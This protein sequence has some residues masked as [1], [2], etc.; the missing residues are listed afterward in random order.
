MQT[1][2]KRGIQS[3]LVTGGLLMLGT[4]IASAQENVSPDAP[5]PPMDAQVQ[6]PIEVDQNNL[7][8]PVG[9]HDLPEIKRDVDTGGVRAL[10]PAN[11]LV[12]S[13]EGGADAVDTTS[14][15]TRGNVV[16]G[17]VVAPVQV[18]GN[19]IAAG[20]PADATSAC[21]QSA[22]SSG[23]IRTDGST[24]PFAG[25]V[26]AAH[27]TNPVAVSGNAV[28]VGSNA[29]SRSTTKQDA[30]AGGDI[31]TSG[32]DSSLSGNITTAQES[33]PAQVTNNAVAAGGMATSTST[34][35]STATS[36]GAL[37]TNGDR[38]TGTGNV[39]GAPV[40]SLVTVNGNGVTA[41]GNA[42]TQAAN[43]STATAGDQKVARNGALR[44][45]DTSG[46]NGTLAGN[47]TEPQL[48]GPVS[49]DDNVAAGVGNADATSTT[50]NQARAGGVTD[51][52]GN[53]STVSGNLGD[54]PVSLPVS[55]GGNALS[56]VGNTS[57]NRA[58]GTTSSA[59][60]ETLTN[61]DRSVLSGNA[62]DAP[63]AAAIDL[64]G[65]G[66][67]AGGIAHAVCA[68]DVES[69]AGGHT[70]TGGNDSTLSG[71]VGE[72]P[73]GVPLE[74]FGN[75]VGA[76]GNASGT[77]REHKSVRSSAS[78]DTRDDNGTVSSNVVTTPTA[79]GA[80]AF[81]DA[82]GLVANPNAKSDS[83]TTV[84]TG[85]PSQATGKHGSMSGN[86]VEIP[87]S[88]PAQVFGDTVVGVGN[89]S[90][91]V[92]N[93][94]DSR[95][96]GSAV[97]TGDEGAVAGNVVSLPEASS[98]QVFGGAVGAVSNVES[99]ADND[100]SSFSG[101]HVLTSG[102]RGSV[103][104]NGL[105]AQ[106]ATALQV[107]ADTAT[108][109]GNGTS[110][111]TDDSTVIAG[112]DHATKAFD[113]S[114]SGNLL[115]VPANAKPGVFGHAATVGGLADA[116]ADTTS[117][118]EADGDTDTSGRGAAS[119]HD[120]ALPVET[121]PVVHNV[122]VEV[123]GTATSKVTD[124]S[125]QRTGE[126][127][128]A[129]LGAPTGVPNG[130]DLPVGVDS[131]MGI[132]DVPTLTSLDRLFWFGS[133]DRLSDLGTSRHLS[134]SAQLLDSTRLLDPMRLLD[135]GDLADTSVLPKLSDLNGYRQLLDLN[136]A[137]LGQA[138]LGQA[139]LGQAPLSQAPLGQAP[140]GQAPL[141][142]LPLDQA[143]LGGLP[144]GGLPLEQVPS[145]V[146]AQ[147]GTL[148][149][150][151]P[152]VLGQLGQGAKPRSAKFD[153]TSKLE[154]ASKLGK[155]SKLEEAATA[156]KLPTVTDGAELPAL[157]NLG[158]PALGN[159]L[160]TVTDPKGLAALS[161]A[162]EM[163]LLTAL[164]RLT[165]AGLPSLVDVKAP[166]LADTGLPAAGGE[167]S[168]GG[169]LPLLDG[170]LGRLA[171]VESM[172]PLP[173]AQQRSL[174]TAPVAVPSTPI[175][176]ASTPVD[177]TSTPVELPSAPAAVPVALPFVLPV[178]GIA[179]PRTAVPTLPET[180]LSGLKIDPLNSLA[181]PLKPETERTYAPAL[182]G[183]DART[184]FGALEDT[185]VMPRI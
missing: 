162:T 97:S 33:L 182:A 123:L 53:D 74:G 2:A 1:W 163:P 44:W 26:V 141:G 174:P 145:P 15:V 110:K 160:T 134:D 150:P 100:F 62:A 101:G 41:V 77:A 109:A 104:G 112:G 5:P 69:S 169:T 54:V 18:C 143:P 36:G 102:D 40:A 132:T 106:P 94:L 167:R 99:E 65:N 66:A 115:A 178:P 58:T 116:A 76:V 136:Q 93:E 95:S 87:T 81:G 88:N 43:T 118:T 52:S 80:Q 153:E 78:T 159:S 38:G 177:L 7:G 39:V 30:T 138:P 46:E 113:S 171:A 161:Q 128:A 185:T 154:K 158:N 98:P 105:T 172:L 125:T 107:F 12:R 47:V 121:R 34:A 31:T 83:D 57:A 146:S 22:T 49:V 164:S 126:D 28:A 60:G 173:K 20:G 35:D 175:D 42:D 59:G 168:F 85:G 75:G 135:T 119:A 10:A 176:L 37:T 148:A 184:V 45:I 156:G 152:D 90:S 124:R 151:Q 79:I 4:G 11:P 68:N 127:D 55:G 56:G 19:A 155:A 91:D 130:I 96:G 149:T 183:L 6:L 32:P 120:E 50:R 133:L 117:L 27:G 25:N 179:Q 142:G 157:P 73:L 17:A 140:L 21:E 3:A 84:V 14:G 16:D 24:E 166:G 70:G 131:L 181:A 114:L 61:G 48:A 137:P 67:T 180:S 86:I 89:G 111:V 23:D 144:L 9:N 8:T 103:S 64:C 122:P 139:P 108:V 165:E 72:T 147:F 29:N 170:G 13:A 82:A 129:F 63:P 71:N 92:T 51:T